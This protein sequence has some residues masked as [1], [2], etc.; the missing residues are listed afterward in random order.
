MRR[1]TA[2]LAGTLVLLLALAALF[3]AGGTLSARLEATTASAAD[4]PKAFS[5]IREVLGSGAAP[6]VF[7]GALPQAEAC[8]LEDVT[9]TLRNNGLFPAEWLYVQAEPA[10]G[11]I[12][13]Y[14]ITGEGGGVAARSTGTINLKLVADAR[15]SGERAYRI[16]YYVFGM[17]RSI[18]VRPEPRQSGDGT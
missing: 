13:V 12:A 16:Q 18:T 2:L 1:S 3:L 9:I 7:A 6:Q 14:S 15:G 11:D 4:Y 17:K 8:R 10:P 5:A